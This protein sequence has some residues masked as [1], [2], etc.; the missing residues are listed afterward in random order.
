MNGVTSIGNGSP[1]TEGWYCKITFTIVSE[2]ACAMVCST[3]ERSPTLLRPSINDVVPAIRN[4]Q[5]MRTPRRSGEYPLFFLRFGTN[6]L[7][8]IIPIIVQE[9]GNVFYC[10]EIDTIEICVI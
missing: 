8:E 5:V 6:I 9:K 10:R 4:T 1:P 3:V 2:P 7:F